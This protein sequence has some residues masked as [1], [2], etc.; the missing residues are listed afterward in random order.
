MFRPIQQIIKKS[1]IQKIN[2]NEIKNKICVCKMIV[3]IEMNGFCQ[4]KFAVQRVK[5][6]K[7]QSL[8]KNIAVLGKIKT[9]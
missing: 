5:N 8:I 4:I 6:A 2:L 1:K 3:V 9:H 7:N